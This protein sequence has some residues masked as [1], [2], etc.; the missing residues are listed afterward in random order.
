MYV[1]IYIYIIPIYMYIYIYIYIYVCIYAG[2]SH[3][4]ALCVCVCVCVCVYIYIIPIYIHIHIYVYTQGPRTQQRSRTTASY[5]RGAVEWVAN[6]ATAI[7]S[8][9]ILVFLFSLF[10]FFSFTL[11]LD[12][13]GAVFKSPD[14]LLMYAPRVCC[15]ERRDFICLDGR[16]R[17]SFSASKGFFIFRI[18]LFVVS[19]RDH[20]M[21]PWA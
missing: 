21:C 12:C 5:I 17:P 20:D 6:W 14:L 3:T 2:A 15:Y 7:K 4:A 19:A 10:S 11:F 13:F 16:W 1:C 8:G 18:F 9:D